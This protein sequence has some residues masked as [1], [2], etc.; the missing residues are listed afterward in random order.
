MYA[1]QR[2][3]KENKC[4][5]TF[6]HSNHLHGRSRPLVPCGTVYRSQC[7]MPIVNLLLVVKSMAV[8]AGM[9]GATNDLQ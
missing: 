8:L 9:S 6:W 3:C 2:H 5:K 1:L 7:A 4:V